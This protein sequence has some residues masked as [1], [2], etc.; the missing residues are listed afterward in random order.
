[1]S[2]A[3]SIPPGIRSDGVMRVGV[4]RSR[5]VV[6]VAFECDAD[7]AGGP[8]HGLTGLDLTAADA[9]AIAEALIRAADEIEAPK[10]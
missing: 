9:R 4:D 7:A 1:M 10:T 5:Q 6:A 2:T 8:A 3:K